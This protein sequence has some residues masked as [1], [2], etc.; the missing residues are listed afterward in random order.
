M[1]Q[2]SAASRTAEG[3]AF[4][5]AAHQVLDAAPRILDDPAIVPLLGGDVAAH[6]LSQRERLD[7]QRARALRAHIVLRS[8]FAED[9]LHAAFERGVRQYIVLG[10]GLDTFALR[11]P[12]WARQLRIFEVDHPASQ[13]AKRARIAA[14]GL[15]LPEDLVFAAVDFESELLAN[16][17]RHA[18]VRLD[19][20]AFFSWLGVTM[21]LTE[22]AID[23]TLS[24]VVG[25]PRGSE[26]VLT[27]AQ[28][29]SAANPTNAPS[30][31]DAAAAL[32]EPWLTYFDPATLEAK[33]RQMGFAEVG[34]LTPA[35]AYAQYFRGRS[36]DLP[37][38]RRTSIAWARV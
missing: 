24:T 37:C 38:P 36:D 8:R 33:L 19:E 28:P 14:S 7:D 11:Q 6:I 31:A 9:Q 26:I 13:V 4:L 1:I 23:A 25:F 30:L 17:L 16:G 34:F 21:Y 29:R 3:V 27:F 5:R 10:A 15:P 2:T 18:G 12:S 20:P 32:G 22:P 35:A